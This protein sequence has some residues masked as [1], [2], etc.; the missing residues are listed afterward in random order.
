MIDDEPHTAL[1][2]PPNTAVFPPAYKVTNGEDSF[3]GPKGEMKEFLEGLTY[4]NDVPT[5]VKEHAFGQLA[6]TDSH[7]D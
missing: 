3:L 5:Y 1:L 2:Y 6:I 7:P 4:A